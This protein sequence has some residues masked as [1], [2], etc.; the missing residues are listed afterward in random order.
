MCYT[1]AILIY[2]APLFN[3][4]F[5]LMPRATTKKSVG[6]KLSQPQFI[7]SLFVLAIIAVIGAVGYLGYGFG[8]KAETGPVSSATLQITAK[9]INT[10]EAAGFNVVPA[11]GVWARKAVLE[12][13]AVTSPINVTRMAIQTATYNGISPFSPADIESIR[14]RDIVSGQILGVGTPAA[15]SAI[16]EVSFTSPL[17]VSTSNAKTL[18]V[19]VLFKQVQPTSVCTVASTCAR[20]GNHSIQKI[21]KGITT[22]EWSS[23]YATLPNVLAYDAV[24]GL[25]V[26]KITL[27]EQAGS[28]PVSVLRK[29]VP[30]VSKISL[31]NTK[32]GFGTA[33]D[34]FKFIV[35]ASYGPGIGGTPS[36]SIGFKAFTVQLKATSG[37]SVNNIVLYRGSTPLIPG[38]SSST[39]SSGDY[40]VF[41]DGKQS[42]STVPSILGSGVSPR[43]LTFVLTNEAAASSAGVAYTI[44]ATPIRIDSSLSSASISTNLMTYPAKAAITGCLTKDAN[45]QAA[46]SVYGGTASAHSYGFFWTD[47]SESPHSD[48]LC[49]NG[50]SKD[51]S[52]DSFIVPSVNTIS[53]T[54]SYP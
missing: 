15:A 25:P 44:K 28:A 3:C 50:G 45:A 40:S 24:T 7:A 30:A 10:G 16:T 11:S 34:L 31:S 19:L 53:E 32:I 21:A 43:R 2:F 37:M 14:I 51:F 48:A 18:E 47:R 22:G 39:G 8:T 5:F 33:Q 9:T 12:L 1:L 29:L 49:T 46:I 35:K 20:S 54:L 4:S 36:G 17:L 26:T 23:A 27:T 42:T 6:S 38:F 41:I 52:S 13:K